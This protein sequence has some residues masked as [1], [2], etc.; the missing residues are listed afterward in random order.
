MAFGAVRRAARSAR[1]ETRMLAS[2]SFLAV[3]FGAANLKLA[4]FELT[5][6]GGLLLKQYG[7]RS[8]GQEGAQD[9]TRES[10]TQRTLNEL[11]SEKSYGS[12]SLNICAPGFHTFSKFVK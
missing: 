2:K 10:V 6:A 8:M 5:D 1:R 7:I 9:A 3:D 11:L 4:E 12:K